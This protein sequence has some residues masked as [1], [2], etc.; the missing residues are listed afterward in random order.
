MY[1][2]EQDVD[3]AQG[4]GGARPTRGATAGPERPEDGRS[5]DRFASVLEATDDLVVF[6]DP[7]GGMIYANRA[8]RDFL[9]EDLGHLGDRPE[10]AEA[11]V[12]VRE[13][14]AVDGPRRWVGD[15]NLTGVAGEARP[16]SL[17]V[18]AHRDDEGV[19]A[20]LSARARDITERVALQEQLRRQATHDPLTGLPNRTML[21]DR[22]RRASAEVG[23]NPDNH[24]ALLFVDLDRFKSI[25]D[26]LGHAVG[27]Q[28]L[29]AISRRV[30]TA[31]R[32][33]DL[34]GRF[35]GDEFVV[36]CEDVESPESAT[37]VAARIA[38][39]LEAP[40]RV[41]GHDIDVG[42]SIG[43]AYADG[44]GDAEEILRDADAA[45]YRAKSG[46]RGRWVMFDEELRRNAMARQD[47]ETDLREALENESLELHYQPIVDCETM[48]V[49]GLE[50]LLR[51]NRDGEVVSPEVFMTVA[52]ETGLIAKIGEWALRG[53]CSQIQKWAGRSGWKDLTVSVNVSPRQIQRPGFVAIVEAAMEFSRVAPGSLSI[54]I[55][56]TMLV[57]DE[58]RA[59]SVLGELRS[60]GVGVAIDDFGTGY[61]SFTYLH[62]LPVDTV[63]V[64]RSFVAGIP[65]DVKKRSIVEAVIN[66]SEILGLR[67]VV[68]GIELPEELEVL[69]DLN[70][71]YVQGNLLLA[72]QPLHS[73]EDAL[74]LRGEQLYLSAPS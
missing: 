44:A 40:F 4:T 15:I 57:D 51:W 63:K 65:G 5:L 71:A 8:T 35:G 39:V 34:I 25:N 59:G 18:L 33:G 7:Q 24:M 2:Q 49:S 9:G 31:V 10:L 74:T 45:M 41:G 48:A 14:L 52:E 36:L 70:C 53:A 13:A 26:N 68:E 28:L 69:R 27:D 19:L 58:N 23:T 60:K 6:T 38:T 17:E 1:E 56:E 66:L 72:A 47:L 50:A 32:P 67:C 21:I 64:D 62:S 20:F 16:M 46:G 11:V 30:R 37:R 43:I 55:T 73:L 61:S 29:C 22:I 42:V 12:F 3:T 54:E